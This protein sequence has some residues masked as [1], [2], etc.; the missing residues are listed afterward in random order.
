MGYG[1]MQDRPI[2]HNGMGGPKSQLGGHAKEKMRTIENGQISAF[3][4]LNR[5]STFG[6]NQMPKV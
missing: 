6:G 1:S 2:S 3:P 5:P 4:T